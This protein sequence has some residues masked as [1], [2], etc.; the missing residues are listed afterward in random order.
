MKKIFGLEDLEREITVQKNI[1]LYWGKKSK[2]I[3]KK[4]HK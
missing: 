2:K 4:I 1:I 3:L